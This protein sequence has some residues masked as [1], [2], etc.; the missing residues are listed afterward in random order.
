MAKSLEGVVLIRANVDT[1]I[2]LSSQYDIDGDYVPRTFALD[3]NA[4]II[5]PLDPQSGRFW[6]FL[7]VSKPDFVVDFVE[8]LKTLQTQPASVAQISQ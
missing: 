1:E 6:Y 2:G 3:S 5:E 8:K 4:R 7:P